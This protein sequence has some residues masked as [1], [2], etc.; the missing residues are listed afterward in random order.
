MQTQPENINLE[1]RKQD[2][3]DQH[4]DVTAGIASQSEEAPHHNPTPGRI[5]P[6]LYNCHN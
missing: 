2:F 4:E 1:S 5:G 3:V 6:A